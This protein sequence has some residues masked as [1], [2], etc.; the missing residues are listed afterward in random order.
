MTRCRCVQF[1][2]EAKKLMVAV[3]TLKRH[4]EVL[5]ETMITFSLVFFMF[6]VS[7]CNK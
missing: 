2:I 5:E 1:R 4:S 6:G 3:A 7:V